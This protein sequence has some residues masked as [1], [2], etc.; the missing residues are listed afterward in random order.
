MSSAR[1]F[2]CVCVCLHTYWFSFAFWFSL[3]DTGILSSFKHETQ[4]CSGPVRDII[5]NL[6]WFFVFVFIAVVHST[7]IHWKLK[8]CIPGLSCWKSEVIDGVGRMR[9]GMA[10][11][12]RAGIG[13]GHVRFGISRHN[14]CSYWQWWIWSSGGRFGSCLERRSLETQQFCCTGAEPSS[15]GKWQRLCFGCG[16]FFFFEKIIVSSFVEDDRSHRKG[17]LMQGGQLGGVM[18][19]TGVG[20]S[21]TAVEGLVLYLEPVAPCNKKGK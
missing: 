16:F 3:K 18:S 21:D 12:D 2:I 11:T 1:S 10:L 7:D 17:K 6:C 19:A 13:L 14:T 15:L 4:M 8:G 5:A 20:G 9:E